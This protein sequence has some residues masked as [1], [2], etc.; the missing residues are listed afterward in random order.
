MEKELDKDLMDLYNLKKTNNVEYNMQL[1]ERIFL[2]I[3]ERLAIIK[4]KKNTI[5]KEIFQVDSDREIKNYIEKLFF[6]YN[7]ESEEIFPK[8]TKLAI[9]TEILSKI[10]EK[11]IGQEHRK[12]TGSFYTEKNVSDYM[13]RES[14]FAILSEFENDIDLKYFLYYPT[15]YKKV[16]KSNLK[17]SEKKS[18]KKIE[19]KLQVIKIIDPACGSGQF[20]INMLKILTELRYCIIKI[21]NNDVSNYTK[22]TLK[23]E[24]VLQNIY[25][26]DL[27]RSAINIAKARLGLAAGL[28]DELTLRKLDQNIKQGNSLK[29]KLESLQSSEEL[30]LFSWY[31]EFE[32]VFEAGGFDIVIGNPPYLGEKGNKEIF[33]DIVKSDFGK[34]HYRGR[35]D[36]IYLFFHLGIDI[37]KKGGIISYITTNYFVTATGA[38]YLRKYI[39]EHSNIIKIINFDDIKMFRDAKGQNSLISLLRKIKEYGYKSELINFRETKKKL[40]KEAISNIIE[41]K[42][43]KIEKIAHQNYFQTDNYYIKINIEDEIIKK[44]LSKLMGES[45]LKE[46]CTINQGIVSGADKLTM[47]HIKKYNVTG[48]KGEG[49]FVLS[50]KELKNK[51]FEDYELQKVKK[52]YK[53]S[54]I[55]KYLCNEIKTENIMYISKNDDIEKYQNIKKHLLKYKTILENKRE[56]K[57]GRLPWYSLNWYRREEIFENE[58]IIAPQRSIR[59][60]FAYNNGDWYASADVYYINVKQEKQSSIDLKYVLA[61]LNSKIYYIWLYYKGKRKGK[62]LELYAKPLGEIPIIRLDKQIEQEIIKKCQIIINLKKEKQNSEKEEKIIDNYLYNF[63]GLSEKELEYIEKI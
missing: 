6:K 30:G 15:K 10:Y 26:V 5:F 62:M 52:F 45:S 31:K 42:N 28:E 43:V 17:D 19:K 44:V 55:R 11:M 60:T 33:R 23:K 14:I 46:Y 39:K 54:D 61:L 53:N 38:I 20:L 4:G 37:A 3:F 50:D 22:D 32:H 1:I 56:C 36:L 18:L 35:S 16:R 13:L 24:I 7:F 29:S 59:N 27:Q 57:N 40:A 12:S 21:L 49:I 9:N 47:M 48:E 41:N 8:E 63:I 34:K 2:E 51:N 58:K 25:G